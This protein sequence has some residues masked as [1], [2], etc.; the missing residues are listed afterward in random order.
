LCAAG[1]GV[2]TSAA[3]TQGVD[4]DDNPAATI[5][6]IPIGKLRGGVK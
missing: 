5:I 6:H 4:H 3:N 2:C 1:A